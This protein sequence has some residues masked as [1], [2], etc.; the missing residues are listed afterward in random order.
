MFSE[1]EELIGRM[2]EKGVNLDEVFYGLL[3]DVCFKE[4]RSD[5]VVG[6]FR[7]MIDVNLRFNLVVYNKLVEGL[8]RV[9]KIDEVKLFFD[10]MVKKLKFNFV[11]YEFMFKV[12]CDVGKV[13]EVF[14]IVDDMLDEG[15]VDFNDD[16]NKIMKDGL[17][18]NGREEE[19]LDR[20]I[21]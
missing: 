15:S 13:D 16:M 6:Y 3:M 17:R 19:E 10:L 4:N 11:S 7:K 8:V 18:S 5:D 14:N 9:G 1:V 20:F 21:E 12:L 2:G